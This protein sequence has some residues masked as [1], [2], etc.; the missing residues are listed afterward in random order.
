MLGWRA[1]RLTRG[2]GVNEVHAS[3]GDGLSAE[4]AIVA[5]PHARAAALLEESAPGLARSIAALE[6]S[7][8]VDLHVVYDRPV[9]R[10]PFAAGVGTPVQYLFDRSAAAGAPAG[11]Q[12]LA[13][14]LSGAERECR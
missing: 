9:L 14:S 7:P 10:Y 11:C 4:V 13:V 8:I 3:G 6:S 2:A 12:Y 1:E 5:L